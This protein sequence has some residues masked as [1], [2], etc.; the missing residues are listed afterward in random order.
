MILVSD[1]NTSKQEN[2]SSI[3]ITLMSL[4]HST[5]KMHMKISSKQT[6]KLVINTRM[7][8]MELAMIEITML[9][10]IIIWRDDNG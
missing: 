3:E 9:M 10:V 7:V 1:I 8:M 4:I 6:T 2:Y 5:D